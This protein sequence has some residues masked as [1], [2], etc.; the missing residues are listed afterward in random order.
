MFHQALITQ[1]LIPLYV[2]SVVGPAGN[3]VED[4]VVSGS[5]VVTV[6]LISNK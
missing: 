3:V 2:P 5:A 6:D 1:S 4:A